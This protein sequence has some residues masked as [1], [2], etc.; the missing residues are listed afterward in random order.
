MKHLPSRDG[1][2]LSRGLPD[3]LDVNI[4]EKGFPLGKAFSFA[5]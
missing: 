3:T 2:F 1:G 5:S 4:N